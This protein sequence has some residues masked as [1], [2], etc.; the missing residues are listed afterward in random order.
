MHKYSANQYVVYLL[1]RRDYSEYELRQKLHHKGYDKKE[2]ESA[3]E[4][5]QS[6]QWQSDVRFCQSVI[7]QRVRQGYGWLRIRQELKQKGIHESLFLPVLEELDI[8]WFDVAEGI[9]MK[10]RPSVWDLKSKQKMWRYMLSRGFESEQ[11]RDLFTCDFDD[12]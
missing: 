4:Q 8:N 1:S 9:F 10:K 11:F 6:Y 7:R 2:A 3:I 5:A 12:E